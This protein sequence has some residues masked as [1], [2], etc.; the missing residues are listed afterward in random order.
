MTDL[1]IDIPDRLFFSSVA[2][3]WWEVDLNSCYVISKVEVFN[4][5]DVGGYR[6][7][8]SDV[9]LIDSDDVVVASCCVASPC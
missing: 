1:Y 2:G 4:R 8:D 6:L 5:H 9:T 7:S 3:P